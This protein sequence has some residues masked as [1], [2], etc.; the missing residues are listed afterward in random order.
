MADALV[1]WERDMERQGLADL[2]GPS[3]KRA[4]AAVAAGEDPSATGRAGT[5]NGA[6]MRIT[7]V[8]VATPVAR[9]IDAV[10][11]VDRVTHDTP[12]A[13]A[14]AAVVATIVSAGVDGEGFE[15]A[16]ALAV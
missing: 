10:R 3:T 4:V 5:T 15:D 6:A 13:H 12:I 2:L 11:E 14:G 9:L 16:A 1:E 7:P 8:G